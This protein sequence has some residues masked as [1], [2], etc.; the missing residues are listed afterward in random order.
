MAKTLRVLMIED[1]GDDALLVIRELTQRGGYRVTS[2]RVET[3]DTMRAALT[4]NDWD[5][6][7][8]DYSMPTFNA[9]AALA[10]LRA[11]GLDIPFIIVSGTVGEEVAVHALK[12]GAHDF[13]S[14]ANL[15]RLVPAVERELREAA[16]RRERR[17]AEDRLRESTSAMAALFGASPLA[18]I[19]IDG[20]GNVQRWNPAAERTFGWSASEVIGKPV[21]FVPESTQ[22]DYRN[23]LG[24]V[25]AGEP[26]FAEEVE[27]AHK[28]GRPLRLTISA[29]PLRD[30]QDQVS[31]VM[32]ILADVTEQRRLEEQFRQAQKMEAV[33]RLAGGI[34]HD[35]NNVLTA[36]TGYSTLLLAD[37]AE[38]DHRRGDI[39][40]ILNAAER[41]GSFT[42][43]LLAFSR[44]QVVQPTVL[45]LNS[46]STELEKLLRRVVT[47]NIELV[48]ELDPALPPVLADRGQI[49]Q[50]L[51]NLVVNARD[52]MPKG[53]TISIRTCRL[54]LPD[55]KPENEL[56]PAGDWVTLELADTGVG[57]P[58]EYMER[59]FEPFFTTKEVGK[60]TGLGLSTVYGIV[61]QAGGHIRVTS[62]V[63]RGSTF[64]IFLAPTTQIETPVRPAPVE[65]RAAVDHAY[66]LVVEDDAAIRSVIRR[67]LERANYRVETVERPSAALKLLSRNPGIDFLLTDLM[68]PEM[69][70]LELL[71][72]VREL[73][74]HLKAL[75]ISGYTEADVSGH[76]ETPLLE[77]PFT[78]WD[79][80]RKLR[81]VMATDVG[82]S[83]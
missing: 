38:S 26:I 80:L 13:L 33:G 41:A 28:D 53:G 20:R 68:L 54:S 37:L 16:S 35:V 2:D 43:Q 61:K 62:E 60:G 24:R 34:A 25:M 3:A 29:A 23:R 21:P 6:V 5:L 64:R 4:Q 17:N 30:A 66:I 71:D 11:S 83:G 46:L 47:E 79:L 74:P 59:M 67:T 19:V 7:I 10:L 14:K 12:A 76:P 77:K 73:R 82:R 31:G 15:S 52:A 48:L 8:S 58:P 51:I 22:G 81:E 70:G 42:R 65:A 27:R 39:Q 36:I 49:E 9:P 56:L 32:M 45:D 78:P 75:F 18:I 72:K 40:E 55:G 57:I 63:G 69:T 50:I 44:K 1:R